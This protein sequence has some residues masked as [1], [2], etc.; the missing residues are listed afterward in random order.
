GQFL[1]VLALTSGVVAVGT[2]A[3]LAWLGV[4]Q[5]VVWGLMAGVFNSIPFFGPVIVTALLGTVAFAQFGTLS[6]AAL[7]AGISLLITTLEGYLLTP[8]LMSRASR[9][10]ALTIFIAILFWSWVWGI[11]GTLLAVPIMMVIKSAC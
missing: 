1:L 2:W 10:N 8:I 5:P 11:A 6:Q 3:A 7:I 4:S 9:M